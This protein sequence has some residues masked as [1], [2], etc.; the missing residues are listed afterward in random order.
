[1]SKVETLRLA[2]GYINFLAEL[3]AS[4]KNPDEAK[5]KKKEPRK[6]VII[7]CPQGKTIDELFLSGCSLQLVEMKE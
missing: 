6:K 5:A 1:M 3:V 4:G 7:H 2:I